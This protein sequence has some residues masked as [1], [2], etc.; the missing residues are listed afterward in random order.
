MLAK[1]FIDSASRT[2]ELGIVVVV[3]NDNSLWGEARS[4]ELETGLNRA[5]EVAIAEGK[6]DLFWQILRLE[7]VKPSLF[8]DHARLAWIG[9]A[10]GFKTIL[11]EFVNNFALGDK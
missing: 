2:R 7:Q 6:S 1:E 5:I 8:D 4:D 3:Y 11:A 10:G 9:A